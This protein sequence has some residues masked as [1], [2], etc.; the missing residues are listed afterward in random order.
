MFLS[1]RVQL[2]QISLYMPLDARDP[3]VF[4]QKFEVLV[5]LS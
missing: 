5:D 1:F 4:T 3:E 2:P